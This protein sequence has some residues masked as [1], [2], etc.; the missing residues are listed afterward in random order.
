MTGM[1]N[2]HEAIERGRKTLLARLTEELKH[3][4]DESSTEQFFDAEATVDR[5]LGALAQRTTALPVAED[6]ACAC[7]V[8]LVT[9]QAVEQRDMSLLGQLCAPEVGVDMVA[10]APQVEEMKT[11]AIARLEKLANDPEPPSDRPL[12]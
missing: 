5:Y 6:L 3:A 7:A 9:T 2:K 12:I 1:R 11:R 4:D 10:I 8:L